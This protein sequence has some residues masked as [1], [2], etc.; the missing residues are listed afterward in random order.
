MNTQQ[1]NA[2]EREMQTEIK[3]SKYFPRDGVLYP[4]PMDEEA[5]EVITRLAEYQVKDQAYKGIPLIRLWLDAHA[6]GDPSNAADPYQQYLMVVRKTAGRLLAQE[7]QGQQVLSAPAMPAPGVMAKG[8]HNGEASTPAPA[9]KAMFPELGTPA[10]GK[11]NPRAKPFSP[12]TSAS[13]QTLRLDETKSAEDGL[14]SFEE[15]CKK[16]GLRVSSANKE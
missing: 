2:R 1:A 13:K 15:R 12:S 3:P 14:A 9:P 7:L 11:L 5:F 6:A 8:G 4:H 10:L 16:L